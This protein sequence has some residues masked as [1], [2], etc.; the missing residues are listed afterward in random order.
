MNLRAL[1]TMPQ[2]TYTIALLVIFFLA[3][4]LRIGL[5]Y[6]F[7]GLSAPP[8]LNAQPDQERYEIVTYNLAR[9]K[10]FAFPEK[11]PIPTG[12]VPP[13][14]P[15]TL[16]PVY[17]IWGRSFAAM[18]IW[19]CLLSAL[20]CVVT[21]WIARP[22]LGRVTAILAAL[23][24]ALYPN[25]FYYAMHLVTEV[26]YALFTAL[27]LAWTVASLVHGRWRDD[28]LAGLFWGASLLTRPQ[29]LLM[30]PLGFCAA[31]LS[32]QSR[33]VYLR[34]WLIQS[35]VV[36]CLVTPWIIRNGIVLGKAALSTH[37]GHTLWDGY[38]ELVFN[39]PAYRQYRGT[40]L[41]TTIPSS[42]AVLLKRHPLSGSEIEQDEQ[43]RQ[44]ALA[45][46][47]SNLS[48]LPSLTLAKLR[49]FLSPFHITENTAV[50]WAFAGGWLVAALCMLFGCG[51]I[52][53]T[54]RAFT[55]VLL[56][57][58]AVVFI[59]CLMFFTIPRYRDAVAPAYMV[60]SAAGVMRVRNWLSKSS[61]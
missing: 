7:V 55:L 9:G 23:M 16:L 29:A 26:P 22:Y 44:Y 12:K 24:L 11:N 57:P 14:L 52:W 60:F 31:L 2:K 48:Q 28:V 25:H 6:Q 50:K 49:L 46:I 51:P 27:A 19:F 32:R 33:R 40:P 37:G 43:A 21:A 35:I 15:I 10:G 17:F 1:D 39:D 34:R 13:G 47:R 30:I 18:R 5:V 61:T 45:S 42:S 4:L 56:L 41:A 20:T 58:C 8:D 3:F 38:N 53:K 59:T 54:N 36:G